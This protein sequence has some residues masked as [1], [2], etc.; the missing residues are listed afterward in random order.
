MGE[1]TTRS[2]SGM[3]KRTFMAIATSFAL[4]I[5][6]LTP[7][8]AGAAEE[9]TV[10]SGTANP[11]DCNNGKGLGALE[12]SGDLEGCLTFFPKD[13]SCMEMNGFALY[14]ESGNE[15]FVGTYDG[16]RG[17]FRT[18][19]TLAATYLAGSCA[20]IDDAVLNG[21]DFPWDRQVTGGC[22]HKIL[23]R[24]GAFAG[25]RGNFNIFDVIPEPGVSGATTFQW[26][27]WIS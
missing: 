17:K 2:R 23:G 13:Y 18:R 24:K 3:R 21:G 10:I 12:F 15:I 19:Y 9:R 20:A 25:K 11:S 14:E 8:P 7:N 26:A 6:L 27:G 1:D 16:A 4:V 5:A 22:D